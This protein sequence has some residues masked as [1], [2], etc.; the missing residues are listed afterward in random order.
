M[1]SNFTVHEQTKNSHMFKDKE[2]PCEFKRKR[3][4]I[5]MCDTRHF[6]IF[7]CSYLIDLCNCSQTAKSVIFLTCLQGFD[8]R[9]FSCS[10][11]MFIVMSHKSHI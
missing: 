9:S 2:M 4:K 11:S 3:E 5:R 10:A 8:F 1:L 7:C 6:F